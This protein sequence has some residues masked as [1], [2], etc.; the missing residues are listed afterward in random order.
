MRRTK[1]D[2]VNHYLDEIK[3]KDIYTAHDYIE[4]CMFLIQMSDKL[5]E[6]DWKALD[7]LEEIKKD[8]E[9]RFGKNE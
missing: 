7:A 6:E 8:L 4:T 9:S 1:E 3:D 2:F 5:D